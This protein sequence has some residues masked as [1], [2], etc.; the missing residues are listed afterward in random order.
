MAAGKVLNLGSTDWC[1]VIP[2]IDCRWLVFSLTKTGWSLVEFSSRRHWLLTR[3]LL[4]RWVINSIL[5]AGSIY[6][7]ITKLLH[8][9]R[10]TSPRR[11]GYVSHSWKKNKTLIW[12]LRTR[13][14][15]VLSRFIAWVHHVGCTMFSTV[16]WSIVTDQITQR[17]KLRSEKGRRLPLE[18]IFDRSRFGNAFSHASLSRFC[19]P[20]SARV[21]Q[22]CFALII[23]LFHSPKGSYRLSDLR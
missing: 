12:H 11:V 21:A 9:R 3:P 19:Y 23:H 5:M 22:F 1:L 20:C 17:G 16:H 14:W 8:S 7:F 6:N 15:H 2:G 4:S 18:D 10:L 13:W